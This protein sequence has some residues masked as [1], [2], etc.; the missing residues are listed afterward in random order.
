MKLSKLDVLVTALVITLLQSIIMS[1]YSAVYAHKTPS[2]YYNVSHVLPITTTVTSHCISL[3]HDQGAF[4]ELSSGGIVVAT[5]GLS[6]FNHH[7][8]SRKSSRLIEDTE[9]DDWVLCVY[10]TQLA[11]S[12]GSSGISSSSSSS[13]SGSSSSSTSRKKDGEHSRDQPAATDGSVSM[14]GGDTLNRQVEHLSIPIMLSSEAYAHKEEMRHNNTPPEVGTS[15]IS[16]STQS[17]SILTSSSVVYIDCL[18]DSP[19]NTSACVGGTPSSP[20]SSSSSLSGACNLRSAVAYCTS[21]W[22][23]TSTDECTVQFPL[24]GDTLLMD[25][26]LGDRRD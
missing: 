22:N 6:A 16:S 12:G 3:N 9:E 11:S 20:S 2:G 7:L 17:V 14:G 19:V 8:T 15:I 26:S 4:S 10:V 21:T 25:P 24:S 23:E 18:V 1:P 5:D 13:S